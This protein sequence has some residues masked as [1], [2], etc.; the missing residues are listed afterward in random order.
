[1]G[2]IA[3]YPFKAFFQPLKLVG[4]GL[5]VKKPPSQTDTVDRHRLVEMLINPRVFWESKELT[6]RPM[7]NGRQ[8]Q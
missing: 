6:T 8:L 2:E 7:L 1:M 3:K 4:G 5:V